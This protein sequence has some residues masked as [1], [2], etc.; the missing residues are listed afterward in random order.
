MRAVKAKRLRLAVYGDYA[1]RDRVY[2]KHHRTGTI[3]ADDRR[4]IYQHAK[5]DPQ[6]FLATFRPGT[7][8]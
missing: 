5:R 8:P 7:R 3:V 4:R 2:R 6:G 1:H